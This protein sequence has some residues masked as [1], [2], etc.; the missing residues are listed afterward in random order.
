MENHVIFVEVDELVQEVA[1]PEH[2]FG[3]LPVGRL[4]QQGAHGLHNNHDKYG[5]LFEGFDLGDVAFGQ[6]V[7]RR[8][9]LFHRHDVSFVSREAIIVNE[10]IIFDPTVSLFCCRFLESTIGLIMFNGIRLETAPNGFTE[11]Q[12]EF[13]APGPP[14]GCRG[15]FPVLISEK[16]KQ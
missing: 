6:G 11:R 12:F 10:D 7:E 9:G 1:V 5:G 16:S 8:N 14:L 4:P 15:R 13:K 3:G 2:L